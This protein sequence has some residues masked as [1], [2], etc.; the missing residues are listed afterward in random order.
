MQALDEADQGAAELHWLAFLLTGE[1]ETSAEVVVETFAMT[2][3]S[4]R[5][6]IVK[7]LAATRGEL[8]ASMRLTKTRRVNRPALPGRDWTLDP[9]TTKRELYTGWT[10]MSSRPCCR[11]SGKC[12]SAVRRHS[13]LDLL[14]DLFLKTS[15]FFM[16][17]N[18]ALG[19]PRS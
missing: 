1:R 11:H 19:E 3:W 8:A 13:I 2:T 16:A 9:G 7:A 5:I 14:S 17:F 10:P 4:R 15:E 6:V 18:L 12:P